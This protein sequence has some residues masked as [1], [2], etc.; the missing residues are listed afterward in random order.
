MQTHSKQEFYKA[1]T[2]AMYQDI[3][4]ILLILLLLTGIRIRVCYTRV[5]LYTCYVRIGLVVLSIILTLVPKWT[6]HQQDNQDLTCFGKPISENK[7]VRDIL[8][9]ITD[10]KCNSIM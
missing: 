5:I 1:I 6:I 2:K 10:A 4:A 9:G 7:K 8:Q 3:P